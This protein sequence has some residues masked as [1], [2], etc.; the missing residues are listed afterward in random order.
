M[1]L[2]NL[3]KSFLRDRDDL[4]TRFERIREGI[5]GT[6]SKFYM[7]RDR[8][9]DQI[10]GLKVLDNEQLAALEVRLKGA[11]KPSEGAIA[12]QLVHPHIVKTLEH[13]VSTQKEQYL[14][15]EYVYG[16]GMNSLIIGKSSQLNGKR[17]AL[18]RQAAEA[19]GAVHEAGF[20]HRDVCP[21]NLMVSEDAQ[22][23]KLIDFGL[24]VPAT[25]EF[26]RPGNRTGT[27]AYM[28]PEVVRR[29][30]TDKR[31]DIFSFGVTCYELLSFAMPWQKG[32]T[33]RTALSHSTEEPTPLTEYVPEVHPR[34]AE[35]VMSCLNANPAERPGSMQDILGV[36]G[37]IERE[38]AA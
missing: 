1:N 28:A 27:P 26:M 24:T 22:S 23:L 9:T 36:L 35:L 38:T 15:M 31:L 21:R 3:L 33:G 12:A 11:K 18:I 25:P 13:G 37:K 30:P 34:L 7:A 10:V 29:K 2:G 32:T 5:S 4:F 16:Q 19:I 14:V 20:I 6:M 17:L 8:H